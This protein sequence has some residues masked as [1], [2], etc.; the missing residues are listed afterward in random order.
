MRNQLL[1]G[2]WVTILPLGVPAVGLELTSLLGVTGVKARCV[3]QFRHAGTTKDKMRP[4]RKS[5]RGRVSQSIMVEAAYN[6]LSCGCTQ[7]R[8]VL[9]FAVRRAVCYSRM[10]CTVV[11]PPMLHGKYRLVQG[12]YLS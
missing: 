10:P 6:V 9:H 1:I 3:Y 2:E 12:D 7:Q 5:G 4:H 11:K 8:L